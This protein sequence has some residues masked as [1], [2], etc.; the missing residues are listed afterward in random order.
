MIQQEKSVVKRRNKE[1]L[2]REM[3]RKRAQKK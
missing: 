2:T 3:R 1:K